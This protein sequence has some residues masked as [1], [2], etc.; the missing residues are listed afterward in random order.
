[1]SNLLFTIQH[2]GSDVFKNGGDMGNILVLP[3]KTCII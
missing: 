2:S 1:M 3:I